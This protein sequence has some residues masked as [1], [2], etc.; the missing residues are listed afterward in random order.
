MEQ[1]NDVIKKYAKL[2]AAYQPSG[3]MTRSTRDILDIQAD[4][5][6]FHLK[7]FRRKIQ[8]KSSDTL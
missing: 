6:S 4:S 1:I 3:G 2:A 8:R 7:N 5:G